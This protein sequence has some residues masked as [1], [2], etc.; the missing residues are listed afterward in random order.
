MSYSPISQAR[1][2]AAKTRHY[3][4]TLNVRTDAD[5]IAALD[6]APAKQTL[7]KKAL[8][9]YLKEDKT[10]DRYSYDEL[11]A[12]ALAF[13]PKAAALA[14]LADWC[15]RYNPRSWNGECYDISDADQPTGSRT[16]WPIYSV[17]EDDP[18]IVG[19][20]IR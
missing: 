6:A 16:L 4:I 11:L 20:E 10:M 8:R 2:K 19:Y 9:A 7:I 12:A 13:P 14:A 15:D 5:L 1:Y 17:S 18:E 3:G